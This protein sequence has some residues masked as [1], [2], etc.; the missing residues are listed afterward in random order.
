MR[1][2]IAKAKRLTRHFLGTLWYDDLIAPGEDLHGTFAGILALLLM[3][4]AGVSLMFIAKYNSV[5]L[6]P[7]PGFLPVRLQTAAE[8][9]AMALDDEALLL[10]GVMVVMAILTVLSWSSLTLDERD[11]AVFGPLPISPT[12]VRSCK[13]MAVAASAAVVAVALNVLPALCFPVVVLAK[14]PVG[15]A[16]VLRWMGA[17]AVAGVAGCAFTFLALFALRSVVA[18]VLPS[19]LAG[20]VLV[21]AQFV[22]VLGLISLLFSLPVLAARTTA[23]FQGPWPGVF[24]LPPLWFVGLEEVLA[25]RGGAVPAA[26]TRFALF[27]L[28][29][30]ATAA[31]TAELTGLLRRRNPAR[32][33]GGLRL[34]RRASGAVRRLAETF[35]EDGRARAGFLFAARTLTRSRRHRS[36]LAGALGLGLAVAGATILGSGHGLAWRG[37]AP[38]LTTALLAVQLNLIFFLVVGIRL[39]ASVPADVEAGWLF[40][41]HLSASRERQL[42]GARS[43]IFVL[44]VLPLLVALLPLHA[45]A[46][47]WYAALVHLAFGVVASLLLLEVVFANVRGIPFVSSFSPGRT[48][49]SLRLPVY[50]LGYIVFV[51]LIPAAE[52]M[53][54]ERA[55]MFYAWLALFAVVVARLI[56]AQSSGFWH[57][58]VPVFEDGPSRDVQ[59]LGL[60]D[61]TG[62]WALD[63]GSAD[64]PTPRRIERDAGG[65]GWPRIRRPRIAGG[66]AGL[67]ERLRAD[68][69]H[70]TRGLLARPGFTVFSIA[71]LALGVG[72]TTAIYSIVYSSVLRPLDVAG[73]DRLVNIYH[74]DP[75]SQGSRPTI[76]LS[77]ADFEDLRGAQTVFSGIAAHAPFFQVGVIAG[78]GERVRGELVSG[79]YFSVLGV[80]PIAGRLLI[81]ADDGPKIPAVAV[82]GE[83]LWQS[84]FGRRPDAVGATLTMA[85]HA[86]VVVGVAPAAFRGVE[87]PNLSPTTVWVP[88]AAADLVGAGYLREGRESR[89]L[90]AKGRLAP[91]RTIDE[92]Q[93]QVSVIAGRLDRTEPL[94]RDLPAIVRT[95]EATS[96]PWTVVPASQRLVTEQSD[97]K[98]RLLGRLTMLAVLLVLLV[99]CS[100][101]ANLMLARGFSRNREFTIRLALG[102][103]RWQI[104]RQQLVEAGIVAFAGGLGALALARLAMRYGVA[105]TLR[106]GPWVSLDSGAPSRRGHRGRGVRF[107]RSCPCH[108]RARSGPAPRPDDRTRLHGLDEQRSGGLEMARAPVVDRVPGRGLGYPGRRG[109]PGGAAHGAGV[110]PRYGPRSR[111]AGGRAA[112]LRQPRLERSTSPAGARRHRRHRRSR[113]KHR[114]RHDCVRVAGWRRRTIGRQSGHPG[115]PVRRAG[116]CGA[117]SDATGGHAGRVSRLRRANRGG[118]AD[119]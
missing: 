109:E 117:A 57:D 95:R 66:V 106:L 14:T 23:A 49:L 100:N 103:T 22:L 8:K 83:R 30:A 31:V 27:G 38:S 17:H 71:T 15:V 54:I 110:E 92:A 63:V 47:G 48:L 99:V 69:F 35:V 50:A 64:A 45:L 16:E 42:A 37:H 29:G 52:W 62:A 24:S 75:F 78:V 74:S 101:L 4:S 2:G 72:V 41:F 77:L 82:I 114:S 90:V 7:R 18:A 91:G 46:W 85:G 102:A 25:G 32:A 9:L 68:L 61:A 13:A 11:E 89:W 86:F 26:L 105:A 111:Q 40:R 115:P 58:Q 81:P 56:A 67:A 12:L 97:G 116:L 119:R 53:L 65:R 88:L 84:R 33:A 6:G 19:R 28:V 80:R 87:L 51:Y 21:M 44:I 107:D 93:A 36:H 59:E 3:L 43:G 113:S 60:A 104:V 55:G 1:I 76:G 94:G 96:R 79:D 39:S 70:A 34:G 73:L 108:L 20:R 112:R 118:A 98:M 5:T 10:A